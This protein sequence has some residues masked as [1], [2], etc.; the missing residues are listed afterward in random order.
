MK[1]V[2]THAHIFD[3][4]V[5]VVEG[6][7]YSPAK[8]ASVESYIDNLDQYGFDYG[9]LIQPSFLGY[10]NSQM[11]AAIAAYPDRLKGIA[12]VPVDS[13][14]AYLQSLKEQGIEGVRLNL[15][16]KE[17][18]DLTEPQWQVFLEHLNSLNWQLEL[19][20][21]PSYL[22]TMMPALKNFSGPI[23][24]DHF[25]RVDPDKGVEDPH[26]QT[27]LD[28]LDPQRYWVKVSAFYRLGVG[29]RG[30][31]NANKALHLLLDCGMEDR[32]VW[33]SDWPHTQ[34]EELSYN[35][36]YEF[37]HALIQNPI[38]RQKVL[39]QNALSLFKLDA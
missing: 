3:A 6:A 4:N 13:E 34:H 18:P 35:L 25:A 14:L 38:L 29:E 5:P 33:G 1:Q 28:H 23:V 7:R 27:M 15:F 30:A 39:S 11:L 16:A 37:L 31:E 26:Y 2:D 12:V 36:N 32:L 17:I 9:V 20:C 19:H 10:D 24:L 21:P 8:S 22:S